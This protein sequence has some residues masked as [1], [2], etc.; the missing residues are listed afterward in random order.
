MKR[1][2][3]SQGRGRSRSE[4]HAKYH[5]D[6]PRRRERS[7]GER[8]P[9]ASGRTLTGRVDKNP[10]G[11][12]FLISSDRTQPDAF[13][14]IDQARSLMSGDTVEYRLR[15]EGRRAAAEILRIVKR[16]REKLLGYLRRGREQ[17][18][19][20]SPEGDFDLDMKT[21]LAP[22]QY[23]LARIVEYPSGRKRGMVHVEEGL[24]THL[25]PKHDYAIVV[26][27][28]GLAEHFGPGAIRD[29][30]NVR[31]EG[32]KEASQLSQGRRDMRQL[33]FVTIDGEDAKD[34][35]DAILVTRGKTDGSYILYVAIADV[36]FFVRPGTSLDREALARGTSVY[37]PGFC[38]PM[39]PEILSNDQCSL[40][41]REDKLTLHAEIHYDRVGN[42]VDKKF[43][44][45]V[46][47]TAHRL[48]YTQ[49]QKFF[50]DPAT[51][52]Q[53]K[54]VEEPMM[55]AKELYQ[56]L[57][58]KRAE[59]GVLDFDLPETKLE[60]DSV[61]RPIAAKRSERWDSHK[62]IEEFMIAANS[63][64][65][66]QLKTSN[67]PALYRVH[68]SPDPNN[69]D[70]LNQLMKALGISH[71]IE[72]ATPKDFSKL[73]EAT[74]GVKGVHTLHQAV[75]RSQRQARYEPDP[76]GHFGLA[77]SDYTHFT[78]P[79]R[80][81][82]DLVVH[83]ALRQL[84]SKE[85]HSDK[86]R[87]DADSLIQLGERTSD[88]ERRAME[89]ERFAVKRKQCWFMRD[90]LGEVYEGTISGA[91]ANG[92][93]VEI[94]QY[95]IDGFLPIESMPGIYEFEEARK[96]FRKRPGHSTLSLGDSIRIQV[97]DVSINEHRIE[98]APAP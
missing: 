50:D 4:K 31:E 48:T 37:F 62:L 70:E 43:Y 75:L 51:Q 40:R 20:A 71:K 94:G 47:K 57:L 44:T 81:Y 35:D 41:P 55:L 89:A 76:K 19:V 29:A 61:G 91:T 54:D 34:Y 80:R 84:I 79:I 25:L 12:A 11:F 26:A 7:G 97:A 60:V 68:E 52:P 17:T 15:K 9:A 16:Q 67:T 66:E 82:P 58:K 42:V 88:S 22:D 18:Y 73:L 46:I 23:V 96:C 92:L 83:R 14:S 95:A 8:G 30:E 3:Q 45:G 74:K 24:G 87:G 32:I 64:V 59:R 49:V 93:F 27:Q 63:A 56:R 98:F 69:L 2:K 1:R 85:K 72:K 39:L 53:M 6:K 13:V 38:L 77:L 65:A 33:P 10:R 90:R 5:Q 86:N 36:A 21:K 28:F 78:S